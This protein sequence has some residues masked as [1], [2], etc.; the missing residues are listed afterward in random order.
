M[1]SATRKKLIKRIRLDEARRALHIMSS[2]DY[3]DLLKRDTITQVGAQVR[4]IKKLE[5]SA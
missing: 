3:G 4:R 5:G 1:D 2:Q